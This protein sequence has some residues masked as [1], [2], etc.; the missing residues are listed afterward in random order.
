[1]PEHSAVEDAIEQVRSAAYPKPE[2]PEADDGVVYEG[3]GN[4]YAPK[5]V[6]L[7]S[8]EDADGHDVLG[9][10][11]PFRFEFVV[12]GGEKVNL[13][14]DQHADVLTLAS[15]VKIESIHRLDNERWGNTPIKPTMVWRSDGTVHENSPVLDAP[16]ITGAAFYSDAA[17]ARGRASERNQLRSL[18]ELAGDAR[19]GETI[20]ASDLVAAAD[21][22]RSDE[23]D[24]VLLDA[25]RSAQ[26]E[27]GLLNG[28]VIDPAGDPVF[29]NVPEGYE[30]LA[31]VLELALKQ[32]AHGKGKDRHANGRSFTE[33]PIMQIGRMVGVGG[34]AYQIAKKAQE[35]TTLA[36]KGRVPAAKAELLGAIV[37]AAAAYRLLGETEITVKPTS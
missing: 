30:E 35:A 18:A 22:A 37:Y 15:G 33:Q 19:A 9:T 32:S 4:G 27:A 3:V 12:G 7:V 28:A 25:V 14:R 5:P 34:H 10:P 21:R 6:P 17:L 11:A 13:I 23:K 29:V 24:R 26:T 20:V 36:G 8:D 16:P 2:P 1:M 31:H